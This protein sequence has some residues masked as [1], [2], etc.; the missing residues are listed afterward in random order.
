MNSSPGTRTGFPRVSTSPKTGCCSTTIWP[1]PAGADRRRPR[2]S[3]APGRARCRARPRPSSIRP[4]SSCGTPAG[5]PG[6]ARRRRRRS[7]RRGRAVLAEQIVAADRG[8]PVLPE[9]RLDR[10]EQDVLAVGGLVV[11]VLGGFA[12]RLPVPASRFD[13]LRVQHGSASSHCARAPRRRTTRRGSTLRRSAAR[14]PARTPR[15]TRRTAGRS[16]R[17][18]CRPPVTGRDHEPVVVE[19]HRRAPPPRSSIIWPWVGT[20]AYGPDAPKPV[21]WQ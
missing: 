1:R 11:L 18:R 2:R 9:L 8:A 3:A 4:A 15:R 19:R 21:A 7:R 5:S 17:R 10:A 16:R 20:S 13:Q 14:V 6:A 12:G